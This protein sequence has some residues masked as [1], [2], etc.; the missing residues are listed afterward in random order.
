MMDLGLFS[1]LSLAR[2]RTADEVIEC[3]SEPWWKHWTSARLIDRVRQL[4]GRPASGFGS[5]R[6]RMA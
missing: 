5:V 6:G 3:G 1:V 2:G 4:A